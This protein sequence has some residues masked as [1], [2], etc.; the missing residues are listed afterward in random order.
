MYKNK[1]NLKEYSIRLIEKLLNDYMVNDPQSADYILVSL[2]DITEITDIIKARQ[3]GKPIITGGMI[4]EYPLIN[5]ISDYVWHGEVYGFRDALHQGED[6]ASM[7]SM[8]SKNQR[9][10]VIDQ[11]ISWAENPIIKVGNRAMYYY[12]AKGCPLRCK[13]C[14]I[15]N[16]RD[17]QTAPEVRYNQALK[18]AGKNLM[19][20]AAFN[21]YGIP[22]GANIGETLLKKYITGEQGAHAKMIRSGV[23]FVT[24][25]LSQNLAKGV[26]IEH[27][28][29]ALARSKS[30]KTK[31]IL[32]FIAGLEPQEVFESYFSRVAVD[33]ATMPAVNVVFTYLDPQPFT[34]F[35][36][37]DIRRKITGIDTKKIFRIITERNKRFRVLPLAGPE[38]STIRT[39]LG[40][41]VSQDDY[42]FI[43]SIGKLSHDEMIKKADER[44]YLL[45]DCDIERI[46]ARPRKTI[47]PAY[48]IAGGV[49]ISQ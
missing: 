25:E 26:T 5:E 9:R 39:M 27:V 42:A 36:D 10:L 46:C 48:W 4:S 13:Y 20:I 21:P 34:P 32:Y 18:V 47:V 30:E 45:G 29:E 35:H 24:P 23:E 22:D 17:Y 43:K 6:P 19:P 14:Y 2:C 3:Y 28:N 15:G 1:T 33:Y 11:R 37:F 44:N 41:C 7:S 31:M 38:K 16:V 49:K 8:T 12:V 40:R